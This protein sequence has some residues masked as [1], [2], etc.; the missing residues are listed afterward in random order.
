MKYTGAILVLFSVLSCLSHANAVRNSPLTVDSFFSNIDLPYKAPSHASNVVFSGSGQNTGLGVYITA[1]KDICVAEYIL[2]VKTDDSTWDAQAT[3]VIF[4][5]EDS[6]NPAYVGEAI[7]LPNTP[8]YTAIKMIVEPCFRMAKSDSAVFG[9][10][11]IKSGTY[12]MK[13]VQRDST[14]PQTTVATISDKGVSLVSNKKNEL[15]TDFAILLHSYQ[16]RD[17]LETED[18]EEIY[19][20]E[21]TSPPVYT[22]QV[23]DDDGE[24]TDAPATDGPE[25]P[26]DGPVTTPAA[27]SGDGQTTPSAGGTSTS[28]QSGATEPG[29]GD[30]TT[31]T[32]SGA[33]QPGGGDQTT[34]T[35]SGATQPGGG[36]GGDQSSTS[37]QS[38]GETI[39]TTQAT[40]P[41][42]ST[43]TSTEAAVPAPLVT[44]ATM[45]STSGSYITVSGQN[46]GSDSTKISVSIENQQCTDV[47]IPAV[48]T[49]RCFIGV[50]TGRGKHIT[51]LVNGVANTDGNTAF[52]RMAPSVSGISISGATISIQGNNFGNNVNVVTIN[53]GSINCPVS[54]AEHNLIVCSV[55]SNAN[56]A[57]VA[58]ADKVTVSLAVDGQ[59]IS[60]TLTL[61]D[62][63]AS[64]STTGEETVINS[65]PTQV[66]SLFLALIVAFATI[67]LV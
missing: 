42:T 16:T 52:H 47:S 44:G 26:T 29:G 17:V 38:A 54:R 61:N 62:S 37:T 64:S 11:A 33:T 22:T 10:R 15:N 59:A 43:T 58:S 25:L 14:H 41:A 51:V 9:L 46:F 36:N 67:I 1:A 23:P 40:N 56:L 7:S 63:N 39:T 50:G 45:A 31:S 34:S 48:N 24:A 18:L 4:S 5:S 8:D 28:T 12:T 27:G 3:P 20:I 66:V 60:A 55:P 21:G 32:Q 2:Y 65:A 57:S 19:E 53:A 49:I 13:T 30:Q 35:Q 6:S